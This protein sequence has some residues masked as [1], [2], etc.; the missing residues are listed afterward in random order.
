MGLG[1]P[2]RNMLIAEMLVNS[3]LKVSI[4]LIVGSPEAGFLLPSEVDRLILPALL[5]G[6]VEQY[7]SKHLDI[8]LKGL[9]TLRAGS[10][11]TALII[12][13]P[14]VLIAVKKS[15]FTLRLY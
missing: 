6:T 11:C 3:D 14:D 5:N 2:R 7:Q 10:I 15:L 12:F 13:T 8:S 1:H 9:I 4:L